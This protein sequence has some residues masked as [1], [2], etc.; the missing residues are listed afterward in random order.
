MLGKYI[1][2]NTDTCCSGLGAGSIDIRSYIY[3]GS[4][5]MAEREPAGVYCVGC[6]N[7]LTSRSTDRRS[8]KIAA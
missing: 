3:A 7:D 8:F 1:I 5:K 6:V 2:V 4:G